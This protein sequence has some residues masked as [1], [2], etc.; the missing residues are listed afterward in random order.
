MK[1]EAANQ[2]IPRVIALPNRPNPLPSNI[3][4]LVVATAMNNAQNRVLIGSCVIKALMEI[5]AIRTNTRI[6]VSMLDRLFPLRRSTMSKPRPPCAFC[7]LTGLRILNPLTA[8]GNLG[9]LP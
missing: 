3:I 4:P 1:L 6:V 7:V 2:T 8:L 9:A 5:L